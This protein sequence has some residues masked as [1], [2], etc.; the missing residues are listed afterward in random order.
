[1]T[2]FP[3]RNATLWDIKQREWFS[4]Q[5][6]F[7]G[8]NPSY[9]AFLN[10]YLKE[11]LPPEAPKTGK[12]EKG[13]EPE[14]KEPAARPARGEERAAAEGPAK[15]EG[16]TKI[17]VYDKDGKL[18]REFDGPGKAGVNR[19]TWDLRWNSP[20]VPTPEQ[21]EAAAAGFDF[22][23]RGPL[24]EPGKYTV[25]IKAG[26]KEA[27]QAVVVEEDPRMQ[28]SAADHAARHEAI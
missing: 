9:G 15:T 6:R 2:F 13:K 12:E 10:Y 22:G 5:K 7:A 14:K 11:A 27:E 26:T 28:M 21:L 4:G 19:T 25:K 24:V 8:K 16:K 3:P 17:T 18:V 1:L 23:P 20:A